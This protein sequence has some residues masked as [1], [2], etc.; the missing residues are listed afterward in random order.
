MDTT[1]IYRVTNKKTIKEIKEELANESKEDLINLIINEKYNEFVSDRANFK[2]DDEPQDTTIANRKS[3][4]K[5]VPYM[6]FYWHHIDFANKSISIG[7]C[8]E[9]IVIM[10]NNKW[11]RPERLLTPEECDKVIEIIEKAMRENEKGEIRKALSELEKLWPY[12]QTLSIE[13]T[14]NNN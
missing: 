11:N 10:E 4:Y 2:E 12:L 14:T 8:E 13:P 7:N 9:Y 1:S 6:G 3:N 5:R